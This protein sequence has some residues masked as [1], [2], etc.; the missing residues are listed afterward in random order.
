MAHVMLH[1]IMNVFHFYSV[2]SVAC[3]HCQI[4]L[5]Y[6]V[7]CFLAFHLWCSGM[8]WMIL[9]WFQLLLLLLATLLFHIPYK[10]Y[11]YCTVF[12]FY[13]PLC[14]FLIAFLSP[15]IATSFNSTFLFHYRGLCCLVSYSGWI[16]RCSLVHYVLLLLLLLL[17][18]HF[19]NGLHAGEGNVT[20]S[21]T[22]ISA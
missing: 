17:L 19:C 12:V 20:H 3:S 2:L 1:S 4:Q 16:C 10:P 5:S 8:F 9:R 14:F 21:W 18:S 6:A 11:F 22:V 13:N 15:E 7:L